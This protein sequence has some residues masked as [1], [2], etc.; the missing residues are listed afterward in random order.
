MLVGFVGNQNHL[1]AGLYSRIRMSSILIFPTS[2][3]V[4]VILVGTF[5]IDLLRAIT[6]SSKKQMG[7]I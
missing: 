6:P 1:S 4:T 2:G 5:V 7:I 3:F